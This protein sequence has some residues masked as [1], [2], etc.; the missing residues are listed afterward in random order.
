MSEDFP[1]PELYAMA[2]CCP[3]SYWQLGKLLFCEEIKFWFPA[4]QIHQLNLRS[5]S[6]YWTKIV[7][8]GPHL[9]KFLDNGKDFAVFSTVWKGRDVYVCSRRILNSSVKA[10]YCLEGLDELLQK[11][12]KEMGC[13]CE[14]SAE[15]SWAAGFSI[16]KFLFLF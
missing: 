9:V 4:L 15:L 14:V 7:L 6:G 10:S 12:I 3:L 13:E 8:L 1:A 5:F 2:H 16:G 11:W